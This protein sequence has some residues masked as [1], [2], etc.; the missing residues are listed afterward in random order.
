MAVAGQMRSL[1]EPIAG[2]DPSGLSAREAE[3]LLGEAV[4]VANAAQALAG[5]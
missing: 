2:V 1:R 5:R 3:D 4:A